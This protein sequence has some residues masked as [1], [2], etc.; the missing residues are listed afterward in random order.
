[1]EEN[2]ARRVVDALRDR[3]VNA[4]IA[5]AGVYRFGVRIQLAD[6]REAEWDTDGTAGLEAQ[7]MRNGVLV[8]YVPDIEGSEDWDE[9]Q[10]IDAILRTDYDQPIAR[11]RVTA[12]PAA[13]PLPRQGGVFRRFLDGFRYR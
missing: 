10:V 7:V 11:Q 13:A 5:R 2:R 8:G 4:Q 12:P 3:G 6:G 1:M 9:D